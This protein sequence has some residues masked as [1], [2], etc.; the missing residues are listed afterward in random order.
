MEFVLVLNM[1]SDYVDYG[2]GATFWI[3]MF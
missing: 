1:P 3:D 2:D